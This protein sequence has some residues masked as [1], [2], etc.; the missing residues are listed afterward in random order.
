MCE[1]HF[2][3]GKFE[4]IYYLGDRP[5]MVL[6]DA[7]S[8]QT[9]DN[10]A[11][12]GYLNRYAHFFMGILNGA[13]SRWMKWRRLLPA[14]SMAGRNMKSGIPLLRERFALYIAAPTDWMPCW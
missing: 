12:D 10:D 1:S 6:S 7:D 5:K 13:D 2:R 9:A 8:G 11:I 3:C 4:Y 14:M